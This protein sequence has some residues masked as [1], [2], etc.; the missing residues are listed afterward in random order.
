MGFFVGGATFQFSRWIEA[1]GDAPR[2][3]RW[4]VAI[5]LALWAVVWI[6]AYLNPLHSMF[7]W[8]S[9]HVSDEAGRLY[10]G[11]SRNLFL[12]LFVFIVVPAT[13]LSLS[14]HEQVLGGRWHRFAFVGDISYST[15]MLHF[16]MQLALAL[17]AVHFALTP[18]A[19]ENPVALILFYVALI[20]L[21]GLSFHYFER[22]MQNFLRRAFGKKSLAPEN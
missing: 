8:L 1:R 22:P 11:G 5:A 21:G 2:I 12:L 19:F 14:L 18:A 6:E 9:G 3:A 10:I 4:S 20:A 7:Y 17:I 13:I 16:P 15:Y